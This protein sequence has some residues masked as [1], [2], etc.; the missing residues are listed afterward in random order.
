[1]DYKP[2]LTDL[3]SDLAVIRRKVSDL[4]TELAQLRIKQTRVEAAMSHYR[5]KSGYE[6]AEGEAQRPETDWSGR[7]P[8]RS[9]KTP[10]NVA[11]DLLQVRSRT[12]VDL[13]LNA[14][15]KEPDRQFQARDIMDVTGIKDHR[16][17]RSTLARLYLEG[18]IEKLARGI[19]RYRL[20]TTDLRAVA[21]GQS[22]VN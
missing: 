21:G 10:K 14:L 12:V 3:Q 17:I 2:I 13:V 5:E 8:E 1:M 11:V 6:R 22:A 7:L 19:Y 20:I 15:Q 9:E 16:Y 4:E 18:R